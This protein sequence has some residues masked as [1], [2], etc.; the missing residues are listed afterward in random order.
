MGLLPGDGKG[1]DALCR[2]PGEQRR[3]E[4]RRVHDL[5]H[6][7]LEADHIYLYPFSL[8]VAPGTDAGRGEGESGK[9]RVTERE[10]ATESS[11][12]A[13]DLSPSLYDNGQL[14]L[15]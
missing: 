8:S 2:L 7:S 13:S 6:L 5:D 15:S 14:R 3:Q 4:R 1:D 9:G 10:R 11:L 12:R